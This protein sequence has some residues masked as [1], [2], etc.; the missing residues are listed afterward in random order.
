[1]APP[2]A[3]LAFVAGVKIESIYTFADRSHYFGAG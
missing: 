3:V 2:L 1:L